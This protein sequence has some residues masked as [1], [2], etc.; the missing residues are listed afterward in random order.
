MVDESTL[1]APPAQC[2]GAFFRLTVRIVRD[3]T[4]HFM[5]Y[6]HTQIDAC[7]SLFERAISGDLAFH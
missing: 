6:I 7:K 2:F 3:R 5:G 1:K 4:F